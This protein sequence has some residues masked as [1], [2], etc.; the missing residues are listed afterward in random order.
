MDILPIY[1]P[2]RSAN[3]SHAEFSRKQS[4]STTIL[5]EKQLCIN[6][7]LR[8]TFATALLTIS[9][10]NS[11][12]QTYMRF[13][14]HTAITKYQLLSILLA[15]TE[16]DPTF[17]THLNT[18]VHNISPQTLLEKIIQPKHTKPP[19]KCFHS[20][21]GYSLTQHYHPKCQKYQQQPL[22]TPY[23]PWWL[24]THR[25]MMMMMEE[26]KIVRAAHAAKE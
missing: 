6:H 1:S 7:H 14:H 22:Q 11:T 19:Q 15:T 2:L 3:A 4:I 5:I 23:L 8:K 10:I 12:P 21:S 20:S 18:R 25:V 24:G 9:I 17:T 13:I 26:K 16:T